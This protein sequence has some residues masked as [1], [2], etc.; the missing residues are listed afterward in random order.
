MSNPVADILIW[1]LL[2]AGTGFGILAFVGLLIFPDIRSR[3]FTASRA[4][5]LSVSLV[6]VAVAIYGISGF[7]GGGGDIYATLLIHT[8]F[9]YGIIVLA[10]IITGRIISEQIPSPM[11]CR[12]PENG[13]ANGNDPR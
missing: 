2:A 6:T 9:L 7:L 8:I 3:M 4:A 12:P 13:S 11:F 10:H 1:L 5:M